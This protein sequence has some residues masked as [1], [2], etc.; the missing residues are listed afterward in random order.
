MN[1]RWT[2]LA[3]LIIGDLSLLLS[4]ALAR[5]IV[6]R[7]IR[8]RHKERAARLKN[9]RLVSGSG[10]S[11]SGNHVVMTDGMDEKALLRAAMRDRVAAGSS[12]S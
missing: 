1:A 11:V 5:F 7:T 10:P 3:L 9:M 12:A 4:L 6:W 2:R 8:A